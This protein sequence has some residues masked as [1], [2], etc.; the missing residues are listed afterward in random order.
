MLAITGIP[1]RLA[2]QMRY[3]FRAFWVFFPGILFLLLILV[4]FWNLAQGKDL[5]VL[6]MERKGFFLLFQFFLSFLVLVSW[7]A[8]RTVAIAKQQSAH[9]A[10]GYLREGY[11]KHMPRFIGFSIF[12][13]VI[14]AF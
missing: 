9:T 3:I 13:I 1:K 7:Y 4:C 10:P 11:Y 14:L 5:M 8:A 12:T 2:S 6:A